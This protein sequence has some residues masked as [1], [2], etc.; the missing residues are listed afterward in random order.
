M[1]GKNKITI[2]CKVDKEIAEKLRERVAGEGKSLNSYLK[3]LVEGES[4]LGKELTEIAFLYEIDGE[5]LVKNVRWL[6]DS[7]KLF[8]KDERLCWNPLAMNEG[9][10][11]VDDKIDSM[12]LSE[13]EK[14]RLKNEILST[15]ES[16]KDFTGNGGGL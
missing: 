5:K 3:E 11:S 16:Q 14:N 4:D 15:L 6:L 8:V 10:V 9:Y 7:G 1:A 13:K 2:G 12:K